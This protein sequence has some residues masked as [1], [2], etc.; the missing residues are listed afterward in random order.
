M[1]WIKIYIDMELY[2]F[3]NE[4][5]DNWMRNFLYEIL[6]MRENSR[7]ENSGIELRIVAKKKEKFKIIK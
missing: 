2:I 7:E 1:D 6:K 5:M 4:I 3:K